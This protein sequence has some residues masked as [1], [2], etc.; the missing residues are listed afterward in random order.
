MVF[1]TTYNP[2]LCLLKIVE[3]LCLVI[4]FSAI[5][6]QLIS[7]VSL[8]GYLYNYLLSISIIAFI[9]CIIWLIANCLIIF[10]YS[11]RFVFILS[12][13]HI[14][15][16]VLVLIPCCILASMIRHVSR[17]HTVKAG[18]AFGMISSMVFLVDAQFHHTLK[19][20]QSEVIE[21]TVKVKDIEQPAATSRT[22]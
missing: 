7:D 20:K 22:V 11:P 6:S 1:T 3:I 8:R 21:R 13:V 15:V 12:S 2:R 14:A 16:G 10:P 17:L 19:P 18:V 5:E 4:S 9:M